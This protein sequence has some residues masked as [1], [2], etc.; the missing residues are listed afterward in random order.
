[1]GKTDQASTERTMLNF[2]LLFAR[3]P[4]NQRKAA[5]EGK[6]KTL[7][8]RQGNDMDDSDEN[9]KKSGSVCSEK[10]SV[11]KTLDDTES[12][13]AE[14][15]READKGTSETDIDNTER[16][17]EEKS[18]VRKSRRLTRN[19]ENLTKEEG[20]VKHLKKETEAKGKAE[21]AGLKTG[22]V[23]MKG[24][25]ELDSSKRE[26]NKKCDNKDISKRSSYL[27]KPDKSEQ[28]VKQ[29][30]SGDGE[31]KAPRRR[32]TEKK[33]ELSEDDDVEN[34]KRV[35]S[36]KEERKNKELVKENSGEGTEILT[37]PVT[38]TKA[39]DG[40]QK[41]EKAAIKTVDNSP[42][43]E[44]TEK[45]SKGSERSKKAVQIENSVK[46]ETDK[47]S[48]DDSDKEH[49]PKEKDSKPSQEDEG[50]S[51]AESVGHDEEFNDDSDYDPEYDP[52]R[53]WCVCRKP[54]GNR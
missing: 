22:D 17:K 21:E 29:E 26:L 35:S 42:A 23:K 38:F 32:K 24:K 46:T 48:A 53:L 5:V 50:D 39:N 9:K 47:S 49:K 52:D 31:E 11:D 7:Q 41:T 1:M 34:T 3:S 14:I 30:K 44:G 15:K 16:D 19:K 54:H 4:R 40:K 51:D 12:Q 43:D 28:T 13:S 33:H 10:V 18:E 8:R 37:K 20:R 6:Q 25:S 36:R 2:F 27:H 45:G